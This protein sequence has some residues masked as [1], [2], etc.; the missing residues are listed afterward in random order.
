MPH[1]KVAWSINHSAYQLFNSPS[2]NAYNPSN[3]SQSSP[4]MRRGHPRQ[5][6]RTG[7]ARRHA[8]SGIASSFART[9]RAPRWARPR[10]VG[11]LKTAGLRT[12]CTLISSY[13]LKIS[14][15]WYTDT[16]NIHVGQHTTYRLIRSWNKKLSQKWCCWR[17]LL[18]LGS[19]T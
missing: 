3:V 15:R 1:K 4:D 2:T 18:N 8:R 10:H 13:W 14:L 17:A 11:C 5:S 6:Q 9:K 7:C 16:I 19:V 12:T